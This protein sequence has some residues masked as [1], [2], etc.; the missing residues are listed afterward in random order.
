VGGGVARKDGLK[1]DPQIFRAGKVVIRVRRPNAAGS[2]PD[3]A[4]DD[5]YVIIDDKGVS[6][7]VN[8][9]LTLD[10]SQTL[11]L[12]SESKIV[13]DTKVIQLY[14]DDSKRLVIKN[15]KPII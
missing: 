10:A 7:Q 8:G 5:Q 2:G 1:K 9:Q 6:I 12:K 15:G 4:G 13:L 14:T 3:A 11:T